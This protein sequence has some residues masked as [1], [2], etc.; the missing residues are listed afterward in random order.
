MNEPVTWA[1]LAWILAAFSSVVMALVALVARVVVA[2]VVRTET[3]LAKAV[4]ALN[5]TVEALK[6]DMLLSRASNGY[7]KEVEDR[8][9]ARIRDLETMMVHARGGLSGGKLTC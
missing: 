9:T 5:A 2:L 8:L 3:R 4:E 6:E 7:V 1:Q